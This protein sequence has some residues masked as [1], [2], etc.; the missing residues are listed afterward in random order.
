MQVAVDATVPYLYL[1]QSARDSITENL[2]V[3]FQPKYG[4]YYW[5]IAD[6]QYKISILAF[7]SELHSSSP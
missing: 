1:P 2:P 7:I 4:R 3:T 6:P 5:N